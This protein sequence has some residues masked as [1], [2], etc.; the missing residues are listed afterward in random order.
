M[1]AEYNGW[2]EQERSDNITLHAEWK[3]KYAHSTKTEIMEQLANACGLGTKLVQH[4][5]RA[6]RLN[7]AAVEFF[8][9]CKHCYQ[10]EIGGYFLSGTVLDDWYANDWRGKKQQIP[11]AAQ[12]FE[13]ALMVISKLER[14][15]Q[16]QA[17]ALPVAKRTS[18]IDSL[19]ALYDTA[20]QEQII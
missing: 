6:D 2:K 20:T 13:R 11:T 5:L 15:R 14:E 16:A 1:Q 12:L 18:T 19:P 10:H 3:A 9:T 8:D 17:H 7:P 4:W